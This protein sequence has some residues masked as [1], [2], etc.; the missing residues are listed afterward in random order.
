MTD[1]LSFLEHDPM[2]I[3]LKMFTSMVAVLLTASV[4]LGVHFLK[5]NQSGPQGV[6]QVGKQDRMKFMV[7]AI[8]AEA[9]KP[10]NI[11]ALFDDMAELQNDTERYEVTGMFADPLLGVEGDAYSSRSFFQGVPDSDLWNSIN[12]ESYYRGEQKRPEGLDWDDRDPA[13][14]TCSTT[15]MGPGNAAT[16]EYLMGAIRVKDVEVR[17]DYINFWARSHATEGTVGIKILTQ[18]TTAALA[19]WSDDSCNAKVLLNDSGWDAQL[20]RLAAHF[21]AHEGDN[22]HWNHFDVRALKGQVVDMLVFDMS[23]SDSCGEI[24]FDHFYQ[25]DIPHGRLADVALAPAPEGM[26]SDSDGIGDARDTY[27]HD[28]LEWSDRDHDG[29][30][31]NAD[32]FPDDPAEVADSDNDG[33]GDNADANPDDPSVTF[34]VTNLSLHLEGTVPR[35]IIETFDDPLAIQANKG[36]YELTGVFADEAVA[37]RGWSGQTWPAHIGKG[38]VGTRVLGREYAPVP[39]E[40]P[41][42]GTIRIRNVALHSD[43][44]NFL[45][46]GGK[47]AFDA[48][49][50]VGVKLY[51]VGTDETLASYISET[52]VHVFRPSKGSWHHFDVSMLNGQSADIYIYDESK[53]RSLTFDHFYQ[54]NVPQ[55]RLADTARKP[56]GSEAVE[57][58]PTKGT[59]P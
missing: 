59:L 13:F 41:P 40:G 22:E 2:K 35:N 52:R 55:G 46:T 21:A 27:P 54:G 47:A 33:V 8:P 4:P 45:M 31:D 11:I 1:S 44:I 28:A 3:H 56:A 43:Y 48:P 14:S 32:R 50:R 51:T 7:Y 42:T 49:G 12:W 39:F 10:E 16:C 23:R 5:P 20:N 9:R 24:V 17:S 26:D 58:F 25:S 6:G 36:R 34:T 37:K 30:G 38:L 29:I 19:S 15:S 18:G 53:Y 57:M